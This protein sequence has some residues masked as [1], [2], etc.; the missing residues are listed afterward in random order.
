MERGRSTVPT[1]PANP[2]LVTVR[3]DRALRADPVLG[4][5]RGKTITVAM[6]AQTL[7][8]GQRAV[9]FTNSWI[10]GRG[11]AVREIEH[12][13]IHEEEQ[14][15]SAVDQLPQVHLVERL[16]SARLVVEAE[17]TR[18]GHVEKSGPERKAAMWATA[19]LHVRRV[20]RGRPTRSAR[21]HF[22]TADWP[23]WTN[24]PRF[25]QNER[26]VFILHPPARNRS[27]SELALEPDSLVALD[28]AD[29]QPESEAS[30]VQELVATI[31]AEGGN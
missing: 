19:E 10:H 2:N 12:A 13:D 29:F 23:P 21:V 27:L 18:I 20:L 5:L 8:P 3:V 6:A 25:K 24:S 7:N 9:F 16:R 26:G 31:A 22:P 28:P 17:V 1:V 4:D 30:K 11:I 15:A 14:V